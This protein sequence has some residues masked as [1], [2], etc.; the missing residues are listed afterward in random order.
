MRKNVLDLNHKEAK[1]F[2]LRQDSYITV[3]L[4]LYF[5]FD[6]VLSE[7][8]KKLGNDYLTIDALTKAKATENIDHVIY[9]NKDGRYA[10]RKFDLINPLIY[11]SLVNLLTEKKNWIIIKERFKELCSNSS[12][13]CLSIPVLPDNNQSQKASQIGEWFKEVERESVKL[14]LS[15]EYYYQTDISNCYGSIY[16]HSVSWAIH[17]REV[18]K[19]NRKFNQLLGNKLDWHLQSVSNGQTNGIPQGSILM[20]FTAELLLAYIDKKLSEKINECIPGKISYQILRYRDDYK[21][22]VRESI[23]GELIVKMLSEILMGLGLH[24]NTTKT[25]SNDEIIFS[26]IK[27]EKKVNLYRNFTKKLSKASLRNELLVIYDLGKIFSNCGSIKTRLTNLYEKVEHKPKKF[28][29]QEE[30]LLAILVNIGF[31]NPIAF[32]IVS[33][34]LSKIISGFD[35]ENKKNI[36]EKI[37]RKIK[38]LPNSG[39]AEMWLQRISV[40][41]KIKV[42]FDEKM[43]NLITKKDTLLFDTTWIDNLS[44]KKIIDNE[45]YIDKTKLSNLDKTIP[46]EEIKLFNRYDL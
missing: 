18:C 1:A 32:P 12:I 34:F 16:T 35:K 23:H 25:K 42:T 30:E 31:D 5:V 45:A 15:Y 26:S 6:N 21:I 40:P 3:D 27:P 20:D 9:G 28:I 43:C 39:F 37:L 41:N 29:G 24:L 46:F 14:S 38:L 13:K 4:P 33:A 36:F 19:N 7:L 17:N 2:F 8:S 11:V 22:F 10:W 44:C